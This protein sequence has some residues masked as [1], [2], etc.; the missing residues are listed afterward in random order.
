MIYLARLVFTEPVLGTVPKN[1]NLYATYI[2]S[3]RR[4]GEE[5]ELQTVEN[6]EERGWT[7]FH[8]DDFGL[9][10]Y[11]Y[12]ILGFFKEAALATRDQHGIKSVTTK[13]ERWVFVQPRRLYFR[14][15]ERIVTEPHGVLERPIR[16]M[17]PQGPR[18]SLI[19]SDYLDAGVRLEFEIHVL[20]QEISQGFLETLLGYG[21][22]KGLGQWR[23]GG[24]G[25]FHYVLKN[26]EKPKGGMRGE[27]RV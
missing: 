2:L 1:Q 21:R 11:N 9:F 24:Y 14:D 23:N 25:T 19:R 10:I 5:D 3:K 17:T 15:G 20:S 13:I 8:R 12:Q 4:S 16:A 26:E 22:W 6:L 27:N 18:V 7:G